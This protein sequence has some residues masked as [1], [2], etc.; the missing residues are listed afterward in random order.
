[1]FDFGHRHAF[2][3]DEFMK[4]R[5]F[6]APAIRIR[7]R[8]A[9]RSAPF[10][11]GEAVRFDGEIIDDHSSVEFREIVVQ[12]AEVE[13]SR[14]ILP[15]IEK[16]EFSTSFVVDRIVELEISMDERGTSVTNLFP[17]QNREQIFRG[18]NRYAV[19]QGW[20]IDALVFAI[21]HLDPLAC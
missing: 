11:V 5:L 2:G 7:K 3:A 6:L 1:R 20:G 12:I 18:G 9:D 4:D 19:D 10:C 8:K 13:L 14:E 21:K 16:E 15:P 17:V